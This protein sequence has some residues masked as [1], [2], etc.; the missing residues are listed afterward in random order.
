LLRKTAA[1][2]GTDGFTLVEVLVALAIL[3]VSLSAIGALVATSVRGTRSLEQHLIELEIARGI[4]AA[5]PDRDQLV[6]GTLQ[7]EAASHRWRIDV[8]RFSAGVNP[9]QTTPWVPHSVTLTVRSPAGNALQIETVR[10]Y[11]RVAP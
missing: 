11:P 2:G 4:A 7:G 5:L 9:A 1:N 8:S 10:L 3:A 6:L